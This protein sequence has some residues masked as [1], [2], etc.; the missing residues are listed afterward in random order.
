V[1]RIMIAAIVLSAGATLGQTSAPAT[2]PAAEPAMT[3]ACPC[4]Q[5]MMNMMNGMQA[6]NGGQM[7]MPM[8]MMMMGNGGMMMMGNGMTQTPASQPGTQPSSAHQGMPGM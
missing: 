4:C 6:Q 2:K 3:M 5:M 1:K 8:G 7:K